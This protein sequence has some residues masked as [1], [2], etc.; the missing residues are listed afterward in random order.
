METRKN[1]DK[2]K[3]RQ[4]NLAICHFVVLLLYYFVT[5]VFFVTFSF[6][7]FEMHPVSADVIGRGGWSVASADK[8]TSEAC[9]LIP[10][11]KLFEAGASNYY[12]VA[13][14]N[15]QFLSAQ[16]PFSSASV[17]F[18]YSSLKFRTVYRESRFSALFSRDITKNLSAGLKINSYG[19]YVSDF[20]ENLNNTAN[21]SDIDFG[22]LLKSGLFNLGVSILGLN[23][24]EIAFSKIPEEKR[25]RYRIGMALNPAEIARIGLD[26]EKNE[27]LSAGIEI[28]IA[29]ALKSAL[30]VRKN[31]FTMGFSV[32]LPFFWINFSA[33]MSNELGNAYFV[34]VSNE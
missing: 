9:V 16:F 29:H 12:S 13:G 31:R 28:G 24:R 34:S 18:L 6:A 26:Y 23:S 4:K 1:K 33:V 7:S 10:S 20:E 30:G 19:I 14:L 2:M 21:F 11:R 25:T 17:G 15:G 5:L 27:P 8:I 3:L 22:I 32:R